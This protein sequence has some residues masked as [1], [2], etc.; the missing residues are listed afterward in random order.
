MKYLIAAGQEY[1]FCAA[2]L[3][4]HYMPLSLRYLPL[5]FFFVITNFHLCFILCGEM[6]NVGIQKISQKGWQV[7]SCTENKNFLSNRSLTLIQ[8]QFS[9]FSHRPTFCNEQSMFKNHVYIY[10]LTYPCPP[11]IWSD[12]YRTVY[13]LRF[14]FDL[15]TFFKSHM[16]GHG[17]DTLRG[18]NVNLQS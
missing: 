3:R 12:M 18:Q 17:E 9:V 11:W 10:C 6:S 8:I 13:T 7:I 15:I 1:K 16:P 4:F 2:T 14:V 5:L